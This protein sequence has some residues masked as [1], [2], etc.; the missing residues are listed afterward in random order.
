MGINNYMVQIELD[1]LERF[2]MK[3][4]KEAMALMISTKEE[5]SNG[6]NQPLFS[7]V[8]RTKLDQVL[9]YLL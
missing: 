9:D 5:K 3:N 2:D 1:I 8:Y 6:G 4:V 7:Y